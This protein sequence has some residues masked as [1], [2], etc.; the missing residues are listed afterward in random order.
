MLVDGESHERTEVTKGEGHNMIPD[1]RILTKNFWCE[2]D[3]K[4]V[5]KIASKFHD[6]IDRTQGDNLSDVST[7]SMHQASSHFVPSCNSLHAIPKIMHFIWLGSEIPRNYNTFIERW[8]SM[9]PHWE[10]NIWDDSSKLLSFC[11]N[12]CHH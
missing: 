9:H 4:F 8:K 1:D 12:C 2:S 5:V 3:E 7:N 11:C 6:W 10:V